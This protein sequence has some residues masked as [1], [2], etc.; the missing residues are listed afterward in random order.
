MSPPVR[1]PHRVLP[2][3]C[4]A[5]L[6]W[7]FAFGLGTQLLTLSMNDQGWTNSAI[8]WNTGV[9][10]LG[11]AVAAVFV[12]RLMRVWGNGCP[13]AGMLLSGGTLLLFPWV[14]LPA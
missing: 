14:P 6:G 1:L 3:M 7:A 12:P 2:I 8:G 10:Y 9:Y 5:T 4:L 11:I 13:V